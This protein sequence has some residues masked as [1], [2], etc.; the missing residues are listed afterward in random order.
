MDRVSSGSLYNREVLPVLIFRPTDNADRQIVG[1]KQKIVENGKEKWDIQNP[2]TGFAKEYG[3]FPI[4]T[5]YMV[6]HNALIVNI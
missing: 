6:P 5:K 1:K 3:K 4:F 2:K